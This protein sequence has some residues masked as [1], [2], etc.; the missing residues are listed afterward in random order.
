MSYT[1]K[2]YPSLTFVSN[3]MSTRISPAEWEVLNVLWEKA[4]AAATDVCQALAGKHDWHPKTVGT[5]LSRLTRKG[6]L[7]VRRDG[8][9][10]FYTPRKTRE[11]CVRVES[12]SFLE[13]IF[14]GASGPMLVHFVE[15]A[16]LSA[17]EI[18]ELERVLKQKKPQS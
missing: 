8:K 6:L 17:E 13:R 2:R 14:R 12:A 18:R 1:R 10:N 11:Q 16:N 3:I 5:F 7:K 15:Q 4:P 9:V